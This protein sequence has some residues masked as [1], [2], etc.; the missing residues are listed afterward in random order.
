MWVKI[1][2]AYMLS[3]LVLPHPRCQQLIW[4]KAQT[5]AVLMCSCHPAGLMEPVSPAFC[6]WRWFG[7]PLHRFPGQKHGSGSFFSRG[8]SAD[9]EQVEISIHVITALCSHC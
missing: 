4:A 3:V 5:I 6:G 1:L 2:Y 7:S 8:G 9:L